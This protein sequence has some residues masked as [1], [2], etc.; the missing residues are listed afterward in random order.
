MAKLRAASEGQM[1]T[2]D[3][4]EPLLEAT[5]DPQT[6]N[7][8]SQSS[9]SRVAAWKVL[10]GTL[11]VVLLLIHLLFVALLRK[12]SFELD[13]LTIPDLCHV[14]TKGA[15]VVEFQNPSYCSP[16]VGATVVTLSKNG[17][18]LLSV[19][20]PGFD[21]QSGVS[22]LVADVDI[23][24]LVDPKT[25]HQLAIA[26]EGA[27]D[28]QGHIPIHISCLLVPFTVNVDVAQIVGVRTDVKSYQDGWIGTW[29]ATWDPLYSTQRVQLPAPRGIINALTSELQ[30]VVAQILKTIALSNFQVET[31]RNEIF[32][33]TD[34]SFNY[35]SRVLWNIP[36]LSI[37]VRSEARETILLAGMKRFL[38]G[39]GNTFISAYTEVFKTETAPLQR[40]LETYLAGHDIG[41]H[42][43]GHNPA[44]NCFSLQV[45]DLVDVNVALPA[46]IEGKPALLRHY[47]IHPTL[48]ELDSTA[49]TCL[50]ELRVLITVNNP[51]P[52]RFDLYEI[53]FDLLY[54]HVKPAP[55]TAAPE[56]L[57][58]IVNTEHIAWGSHE[59]HN[60]TLLGIVRRFEACEQ[61]ITMYMHN[62]L[63]FQ[64]QHGNIEVGA[65]SGNLSIPF[66][67]DEI[68]IHPSITGSEGDT[69][70]VFA[71]ENDGEIA[72]T[73][74]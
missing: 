39:G 49:K 20:L 54:K 71:L 45:L 57:A 13:Q 21:L 27:F 25:L 24:M 48:K 70:G 69:I 34:V 35:A 38:L 28:V 3:D 18:T 19:S 60:V 11:T 63:A 72:A 7:E 31:D 6:K 37:R 62:T 74:R 66:S 56:K 9:R 8:P 30:R 40:M 67:V 58:H 42:V 17:T 23:R 32:A 29:I 22:T 55:P 61:V 52:I 43:S 41:L 2:S 15:V 68:P 14:E 44:A 59:H 47:E 16:T 10:L 12:T 73:G 26:D 46:K 53:E 36:S 51:L 1:S 5:E 50:L 33:F 4:L 65:A 64:I